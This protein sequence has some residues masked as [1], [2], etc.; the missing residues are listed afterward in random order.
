MLKGLFGYESAFRRYIGAA[1]QSFL[2]DSIMYAEVRPNFFDKYIVSDD[3][4]TK[5]DH[6]A[7][8]KIIQEEIDVKM[9]ELEA[10]G[11]RRDFCGVKIIYCAPRSIEKK[12]M[13]WCL[14]DCIA[15]KRAFP[16]LICGRYCGIHLSDD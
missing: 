2:D 14:D 3:G 9:R 15:L 11:R 8:M 6:T 1:I 16:D 7:W 12:D 4:E 5:L 10:S 13:I